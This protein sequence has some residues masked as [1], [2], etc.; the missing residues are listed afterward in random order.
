VNLRITRLVAKV[1]RRTP[2]A[3][4]LFVQGQGWIGSR[5]FR[6]R[7]TTTIAPGR[8]YP[9]HDLDVSNIEVDHDTLCT[10]VHALLDEGTLT[11]L[12]LERICGEDVEA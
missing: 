6:F 11:H 10:L 5:C 7:G 2:L 1:T 8:D 3:S 9:S 12:E 4:I